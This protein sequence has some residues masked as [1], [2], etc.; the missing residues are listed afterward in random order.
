M[1][2]KNEERFLA[3]ALRSVTGVVDE[4]CVVDTGSTDGTVAIAESFGARLKRVEWRDDFA[5]ARNQA[6]TMATHRWI[7]MLDAD[8]RLAES[9]HDGVRAIG[10]T[11]AAGRGKWIMCRNL[12]DEIKGSGAMTNALVRIF[13]NDP[14]IRY[15]NP[16]HEFVARDGAEGGLPSDKTAIEII[17]H[18]YLTEVVRDR[19]KAERNLRLSRSAV[20]REPDDPFHH[21]NFGMALLLAGDREGAAAALA[22]TRQMTRQTPRGFR[23]HALAAL[24]DLYNERDTDSGAAIETITE[25]L[26]VAPNYSTAHFTHGKILAKRGEFHAAR[27][28]FGRA[29]AAGEH[30]AEQFVVDN[31]VAIWKA[32]SEIG[33][34]LMHEKR[35]AD[36]LKW[37]ELAS[38]AR[39][40]AAPLLV[41]RAKCHEQLGDLGSAATLYRAAFDAF[42]DEASAIEWVNFLLRAGRENEALDAIE[43]CLACV[44]PGYQCVFLGTA[45]LVHLRAGRESEAAEALERALA[46]LHPA[47]ARQTLMALAE[48][49]GAPDLVKMLPASVPARAP[50]LRIAYN[51]EQ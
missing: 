48:R 6:I 49:M 9:S 42:K 47:E 3:D 36:A 5:W 38:A 15:R 22:Q 25:C 27:D 2:V 32:H 12:S 26:T 50:G 10:S 44:S 46:A 35:Y 43:A 34:T 29:I 45:A 4:I 21:Y 40:M 1:I 24:A 19:E 23:A 51:P 8:E 14:R 7:F 30:D 33:A 39:P 37:F 17:H 11:S 18:G 31:E 16:I 13:P 20:E 41:N 28:A